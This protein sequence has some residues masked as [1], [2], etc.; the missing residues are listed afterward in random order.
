MVRQRSRA[1]TFT[2]HNQ[3]DYDNDKKQKFIDLIKSKY[4]VTGYIVAQE[5]YPNADK[6]NL[7]EDKL[8]D[9][10]L[11][12][13]LYFK[14]QVDFHPLLKFIQTH[15]PEEKTEKGLLGRTQLLAIQKGT[16]TQ[17]DNYFKGQSK[18]GGDPELLTNMDLKIAEKEMHMINRLLEEAVFKAFPNIEKSSMEK[19]IWEN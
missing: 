13:N 16:D 3:G 12:G 6:T 18:M 8:G 15:Y 17:M 7:D 14:H 2:I 10:H 5:L 4:E 1:Y 11:Q 9:S 19:W